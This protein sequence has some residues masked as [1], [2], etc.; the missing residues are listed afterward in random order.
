MREKFTIVATTLLLFGLVVTGCNKEFRSMVKKSKSRSIQDIDT[1]AVYFYNRKKYD[2]AIPLFEQLVP[3]MAGTS[4]QPELYYYYAW[5][6]YMMGELVSSAFYFEDFSQKFPSNEH[7]TECEWMVAKC[8][9]RL[10]DPHYLDQTY[11]DK[12]I[13]QLQ[14]FLSRNPKSDYEED[15]MGYLND[16][17]ERKAKKAFE[18][19]KLYY[20]LG[21]FKAAVKAF[22]VMISEYPDSDFREESQFL[23]FKSAYSLAGV[24]TDRR[25]VERYQEAGVFYERFAKK[26]PESKFAKEAANLDDSGKKSLEKLRLEELEREQVKLYKSI[27]ENVNLALRTKDE[28]ERAKAKSRALKSYEEL[29]DD[30]PDSE[31]LPKADQLY[32]KLS[33]GQSGEQE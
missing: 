9:Y 28:E 2:R 4:R 3:A 6:R 7:A 14:L 26:F 10:S 16:L 33:M 32:S 18:Q 17:R 24:S 11:T 31:Y 29:R 22:E 30:Y 15:C 13:A 20:N 5:S 25:K 21:Y 8:Y 23:L 1:A 19:A 27:E 12:A